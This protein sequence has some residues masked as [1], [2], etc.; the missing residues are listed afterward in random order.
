M[1]SN[2]NVWTPALSSG[3]RKLMHALFR[4]LIALEIRFSPC[5]NWMKWFPNFIEWT[6]AAV[7]AVHASGVHFQCCQFCMPHSESI[8]TSSP[9]FAV[10]HGHNK[11]PICEIIWLVLELSWNSR[12][13][14][15]PSSLF[16][17]GFYQAVHCLWGSFYST[18]PEMSLIHY[19]NLSK[20]MIIFQNS[21]F[22]A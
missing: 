2:E 11:G 3:T 16:R 15:R 12:P 14:Q 9:F 8:A 10:L 5:Q 6:S 20:N 4:C 19:S 13:K 18:L 7:Q 22:V 21:D 1:K 17:E